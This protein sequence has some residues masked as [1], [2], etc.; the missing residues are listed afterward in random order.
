MKHYYLI[1]FTLLLPFRSIGQQQRTLCSLNAIPAGWVITDVIKNCKANACAGKSNTC[2]IITD[3]TNMVDGSTLT[4]CAFNNPPPGWKVLKVNYCNCCGATS[5]GAGVQ[6]LIRRES[7][8]PQPPAQPQPASVPSTPPL[9]Q[10]ITDEILPKFPSEIPG[11]NG[12]Y[13][14]RMKTYEDIDV[15][16]FNWRNSNKAIRVNLADGC[17]Q[18]KPEYC[19]LLALCYNWCTTQ[20]QSQID[21]KIY[22]R[23]SALFNNL[24]L[25][26]EKLNKAQLDNN[27]TAKAEAEA[28]VDKVLIQ[29]STKLESS[30]M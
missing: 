16:S 5:P 22:S 28:E 27:K 1:V 30:K 21:M 18:G 24:G 23:A 20:V 13:I 8:K 12:S 6:W 7:G 25:A 4:M 3:L 19:K 9:P 15:K 29:I 17:T 10:G 26:F 14:D 11:G 2:W